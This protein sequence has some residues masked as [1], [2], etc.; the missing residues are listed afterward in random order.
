MSAPDGI[1]AVTALTTLADYLVRNGATPDAAIA[2]I[3]SAF[4]ISAVD[5][6]ALN[7]T[8]KTLRIHQLVFG[9]LAGYEEENQVL[10]DSANY[11]RTRARSV[12][13][14][15]T[16]TDLPKLIG[17]ETTAFLNIS[18]VIGWLNNQNFYID[19]TSF[20]DL[21]IGNAFATAPAAVRLKGKLSKQKIAAA[22]TI[23]ADPYCPEPPIGISY[24]E[25]GRMIFGSANYRRGEDKQDGYGSHQGV[26]QLFA[27]SCGAE[28]L[29]YNGSLLGWH[30]G[31]DYRVPEP[32]LTDIVRRAVPQ[33][34]VA[35]GTVV[36]VSPR[37]TSYDGLSNY[38]MVIIQDQSNLNLFWRY[39]HLDNSSVSLNQVIS[40]G[41]EIGKSGGVGKTRNHFG[42]HAHI[43]AWIEP[44][45]VDPKFS[46]PYQA[47]RKD[48]M[49]TLKFVNPRLYIDKFLE[50]HKQSCASAPLVASNSWIYKGELTTTNLVRAAGFASDGSA[51]LVN[52]NGAI[53]KWNISSNIFTKIGSS[54]PA[55]SDF[56]LTYIPGIYSASVYEDRVVLGAN[57]ATAIPIYSLKTLQRTDQIPFTKS[58][59]GKNGLTRSRSAFPEFVTFSKTGSDIVVFSASTWTADGINTGEKIS[60]PNASASSAQLSVPGPLCARAAY[61]GRNGID[62]T[63]VVTC[64]GVVYYINTNGIP[65]VLDSL[66]S[67]ST[68][69]SIAISKNGDKLLLSYDSITGVRE[70]KLY[71]ISNTSDIPTL[72]SS[73]IFGS[74]TTYPLF[75]S[76]NASEDQ[77]FMQRYF[78]FQILDEVGVVQQTINYPAGVSGVPSSSE[79]RIAFSPTEKIMLVPLNSKVLVYKKQ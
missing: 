77:I 48:V 79:G 43:E 6:T 50:P 70:V 22:S 52:G 14:Q 5:V 15:K 63:V 27:G 37:S 24:P 1:K 76:F 38:G 21:V 51:Y 32:G 66:S 29:T 40:R 28:T 78:D 33:Y 65:T 71:N 23:T 18:E 2:Q 42:I 55:A 56:G 11:Y 41:C 59:M 72:R 25:L 62:G 64:V 12:A 19:S 54:T 44:S 39:L 58:K 46:T 47:V 13:A 61:R 69:N 67:V 8:S 45:S 4:S 10:F 35:N 49:E 20:S 75:P 53:E 3:A 16:L 7:P 34:S 60:I 17:N 9:A 68:M 31:I 57:A 30:T 74:Q 26:N 36:Y 73:R